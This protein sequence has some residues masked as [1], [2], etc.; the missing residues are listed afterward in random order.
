[1]QK[2]SI[3]FF[4]THNFAATILE[5]LLKS[6]FVS[7][8]LVITQPDRPVGREQKLQPSPVKILAQ[9][10]NLPIDQ[11][12]NL[13]N[14]EL[15]VTSYGL[16]LA[17]VAQYGL[18]IPE[19]IINAP[20]LGTLN[21]HTSLLPKYRGA[22]PIQ[23]ALINGE[24]KTGVTIMKMDKGLDTGPILLQKTLK[25]SPDDTYTILDEKLAKIGLQALTEALPKYIQGKLKPKPQ[26]NAKATACKQL[27]R[28]DGK[29]DWN[30]PAQEIYNLYRGLTPWP[31]VWTQWENKRLKLLRIQPA[32]RKLGS[33]QVAVENDKIFIGCDK[34]SIEVLELQLEGKKAT[35]AKMFINGHQNIDDT[36]LK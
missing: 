16:H 22:S 28:E 11:P 32:N 29:I 30:K 31:G 6:P 14:Y 25:I 19:N 3:I 4:G 1:M 7:V 35:T 24:K 23:S 13:K 26:K 2:I 20:K 36:M 27:T 34:K 33:G 12:Q 10:H 21:I 5:G 8:D 9:K 17:I 18:L 15:R